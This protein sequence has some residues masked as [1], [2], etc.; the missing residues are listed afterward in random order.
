MTTT[1]LY[2]PKNE[3]RVADYCADSLS[4]SGFDVV[5][6]KS[7]KFDIVETTS[8]SPC[9]KKIVAR[10]IGD[11]ITLF[12][13][14]E[15]LKTLDTGALNGSLAHYAL[16]GALLSVDTDDE[17][18][19]IYNKIK[20]LNKIAPSSLYKFRLTPLRESW[21]GLK[22]LTEVLLKQGSTKDDLYELASYFISGGDI[23][24]KATIT[25]DNPPTVEIDGRK[26][27]VPALTGIADV[28][29][30]LT[31][32]RERPKSI[33]ISNKEALSPELLY[34]LRG[35]GESEI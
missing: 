35:L 29:L 8:S 5:R 32:V 28:D 6:H 1:I 13:K 11:A 31:V 33:V 27:S 9:L 23:A 25:S 26:I 4:G 30:L 10:T 2:L 15:V 20:R 3:F 12:Y 14:F 21:E 7:L 24:P 17:R 19:Q 22:T 18:K 34:A 16:I